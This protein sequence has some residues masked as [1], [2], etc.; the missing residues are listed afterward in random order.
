M[1]TCHLRELAEQLESN[2]IDATALVAQDA[3][4]YAALDAA[5][6]A[7]KNAMCFHMGE[8][9]EMDGFRCI[10]E[11]VRLPFS[12]C[13]FEFDHT[14]AGGISRFGV[15]AREVES[16]TVWFVFCRPAG[17]K[18]WQIIG[19]ASIAEKTDEGI[20]WAVRP[21]AIED[22]APSVLEILHI[23]SAFL[24]ALNCANVSKVENRPEPKIQRAREKRGKLPLFSFW[25]LAL[26]W[27][28]DQDN[29]PRGGTHASPR[30]HLR[31][32]H[33]RQYALGKWTWVQPHAVGNKKAGIVH[34]D[35]A[36]TRVSNAQVTGA[37]PTGDSKSDER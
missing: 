19:W 32:G 29:E 35:Y 1:T 24:S 27:T 28:S 9:E 7:A 26:D 21:K 6:L 12:A 8:G 23:V 37:A 10:P 15:L 4:V 2:E 30:L 22:Y 5:E 14:R 25:T 3:R 13:W 17:Q 33:A 16:E 34:K 20:R 36:L 11:L 18:H 31:R